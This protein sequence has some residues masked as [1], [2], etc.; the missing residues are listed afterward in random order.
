MC[1]SP[2]G[3]QIAVAMFFYTIAPLCGLHHP[4]ADEGVAGLNAMN[5]QNHLLLARESI[6]R[7][8]GLAGITE[9]CVGFII[10]LGSSC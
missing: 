8:K 9:T 1:R 7:G 4:G 6:N 3:S 5:P 2:R 10:R